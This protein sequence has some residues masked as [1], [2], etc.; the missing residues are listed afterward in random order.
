M[1]KILELFLFFNIIFLSTESRVLYLVST[2]EFKN[3]IKST[4]NFFGSKEK[5][6]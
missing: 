3:N 1:D 2:A 4:G 5:Y 6:F